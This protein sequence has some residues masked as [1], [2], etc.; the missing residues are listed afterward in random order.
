MT[1]SSLIPV[2]VPWQI[3]AELEQAKQEL[4]QAEAEL[5]AEQAAVNAF[6]MHCRLKLDTLVDE[7]QELTTRKQS[8]LTRLALLRQARD[9]GEFDDDDAFWQTAVPP[10]P[11]I[12]DDA[13]DLLLPTDTPRDKAAEKRLYRELARRFHPDLAKT[14][15]EEAYRTSVMTAVNAAYERQDI[16]TLYDL[17]GE[18]DPSELAELQGIETLEIRR[19]REQIMKMRRLRRKAIQR[20]KTLRQENTARLWRKAQELEEEGDNWWDS[21]RRELETAVARRQQTVDALAAQVKLLE[22]EMAEQTEERDG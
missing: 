18:L 1:D 3:R 7:L 11:D 22:E 14:A 21:V 9:A 12:P 4:R 8:L 5:A 16:Q 15:V 13:D 2:P 6:R 19:L 10:E 20:L 17:A